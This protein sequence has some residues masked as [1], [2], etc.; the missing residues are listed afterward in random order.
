MAR[1][2]SSVTQHLRPALRGSVTQRAALGVGAFA[3]SGAKVPQARGMGG[4]AERPAS[5]SEASP[6]RQVSGIADRLRLTHT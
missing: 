5:G 2:P 4:E 6:E 1:S 3:I